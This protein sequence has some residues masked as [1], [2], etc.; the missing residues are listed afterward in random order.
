M[1]SALAFNELSFNYCYI[2]LLRVEKCV[3]VEIRQTCYEHF[4]KDLL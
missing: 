1:M 4:L 3:V 2:V